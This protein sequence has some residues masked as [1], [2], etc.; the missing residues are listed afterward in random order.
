MQW[1][2][3]RLL[4]VLLAIAGIIVLFASFLATREPQIKTGPASASNW[5]GEDIFAKPSSAF[6]AGTSPI[7]AATQDDSQGFAPAGTDDRV[8]SYPY[9]N[10]FSG[11]SEQIAAQT[12]ADIAEGSPPAQSASAEA[13]KTADTGINSFFNNAY[14]LLPR[15]LIS[16][17]IPKPETRTSEEQALYDYGNAVGANIKEFESTHKNNTALKNFFPEQG[18]YSSGDSSAVN[19]VILLASDYSQL[20][21]TIASI[22]S[23][24]EGVQALH[25]AL[26]KSYV[27]VGG[28]LAVIASTKAGGDII[29]AI[30]AY[31]N[32]AGIFIKN[33]VALAEFFSARGIKFSAGDPGSVFRFSR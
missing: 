1:L 30:L 2:R 33:F 23:V 25:L 3:A 6:G 13:E 28:G 27:E 7:D 5:S 21:K 8:F 29:P 24:P 10:P 4:L 19:A 15:G 17:S 14:S 18:G 32:S 22:G 26:A 11:A 31:D 20:G 16:V 9:P 12:G